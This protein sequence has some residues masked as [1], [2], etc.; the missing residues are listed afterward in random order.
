MILSAFHM[1][2]FFT[3]TYDLI[4]FSRFICHPVTFIMQHRHFHASGFFSCVTIQFH[5]TSVS[6][7]N[8][9]FLPVFSFE[10]QRQIATTPVA[11]KRKKRVIIKRQI[12][13]KSLQITVRKLLQNTKSTRPSNVSAGAHSYIKE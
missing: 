4:P 9:H 2:C 8:G 3:G 12:P 13:T 6:C 5:T 7:S 10:N 11:T 1:C